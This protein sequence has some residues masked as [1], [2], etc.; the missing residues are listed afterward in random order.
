MDR[1]MLEQRNPAEALTV[2][3]LKFSISSNQQA[4]TRFCEAGF[5][6]LPIPI[7]RSRCQLD[8]YELV[9][10]EVEHP[11]LDMVGAVYPW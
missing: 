4:I 3:V 6:R 8:L 2:S 10:A 5:K 9:L 11:M 7:R 1:T